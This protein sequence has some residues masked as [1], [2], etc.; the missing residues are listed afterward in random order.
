MAK[1]EEQLF[2]IVQQEL[3]VEPGLLTTSSRL[4]DHGDSLDLVSLLMALEDAFGIRISTE[5]S[6]S[7]DTVGDLLD[8]LKESSVA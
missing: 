8:L 4:A 6:L 3:G 1:I 2:V 7:I 5:Q